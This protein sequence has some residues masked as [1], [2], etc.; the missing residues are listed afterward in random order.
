MLS[1][2]YTT[3]LCTS[4][5]RTAQRT[6]R[7][8]SRS[9]TTLCKYD[10]PHM[11]TLCH[12][13]Y[14]G[15]D[16]YDHS[17]L[18]HLTEATRTNASA[19]TPQ[20]SSTA[21]SNSP[22]NSNAKPSG[23]ASSNLSKQ[24]GHKPSPNGTPDAK[25]P[26]SPAPNTPSAKTAKSTVCTWTTVCLNLP[27]PFASRQTLTYPASYLP[28]STNL[29]LSAQTLTGMLTEQ[30]LLSKA[31]IYDLELG[32]R[33]GLS[34]TN[35][36]LCASCTARNY[37]RPT[38][39]PSVLISSV[40]GVHETPKDVLPPEATVGSICRRTPPC[41]WTILWIFCTTV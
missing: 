34:S 31:S 13:R 2:R 15:T 5:C 20:S 12:S 33:S 29:H 27:L 35:A 11:I 4:R 22:S 9:C 25:K 26:S 8:F 32:R 21:H 24:T 3:A 38:R 30:A 17:V 18:S 36:I 28:H 39:V 16:R 1:Q 10:P 23:T 40:C 6:W 19:R 37:S 7:A 14:R 41:R